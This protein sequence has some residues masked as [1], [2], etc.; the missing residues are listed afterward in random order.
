MTPGASWLRHAGLGGRRI[1]RR[2]PAPITSAPSTSPSVCMYS[3]CPSA[4]S[5]TTSIGGMFLFSFL[6]FFSTQMRGRPPSDLG[7]DATHLG[8]DFAHDLSAADLARAS[9]LVASDD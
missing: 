9:E 2:R 1:R 6:R 7:G 4:V 8:G 3:G 5:P